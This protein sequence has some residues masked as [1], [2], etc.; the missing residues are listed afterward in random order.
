MLDYKCR[1]LRGDSSD[2]TSEA[3]EIN[4]ENDFGRTAALS[5]PLAAFQFVTRELQW[6]RKGNG[7]VAMRDQREIQEF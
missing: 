7:K 2:V 4:G 5:V 3:A 1:I 6:R